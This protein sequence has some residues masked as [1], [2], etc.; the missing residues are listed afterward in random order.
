MRR[1]L[2]VL[3]LILACV[4][5]D[6]GAVAKN[7]SGTAFAAKGA[8]T[9]ADL[10]TFTVSTGSNLCLIGILHTSGSLSGSS[11]TWDNAGTPQAMTSAI[12]TVNSVRNEIFYLIAPHT[13]NLTLHAA[14]TTSR[15]SVLGA[16]AFSGADQTTCVKAADSIS[17]TGSVTPSTVTVTS[18]TGGATVAA[19]N[20]ATTITSTTTQTSIYL[21]NSGSD[22]AASY[23]LGGTSNAHTWA[24]TGN[25]IANGVHVLAASSCKPTLML[26]G[27]TRC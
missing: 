18:T 13:G 10:T 19:T 9:T 4:R 12:A 20:A 11:M 14:W 7:D 17:A 3:C 8:S 5:I 23:A 16:I 2:T 26:I 1:L 15:S 24:L 22:G 25:W 27:I 21:S 6:F